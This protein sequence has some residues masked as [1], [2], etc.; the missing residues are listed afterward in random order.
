M[1]ILLIKFIALTATLKL[2]YNQNTYPKVLLKL[3]TNVSSNFMIFNILF[4]FITRKDTLMNFTKGHVA[5]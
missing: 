1:H 4:Y 2:V 3:Q 5:F